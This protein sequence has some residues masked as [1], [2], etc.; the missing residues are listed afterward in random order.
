MKPISDEFSPEALKV[1][2]LDRDELI[3]EAPR[4]EAAMAAAYD[5]VN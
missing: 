4:P 2:G 1:S 3:E 5:W